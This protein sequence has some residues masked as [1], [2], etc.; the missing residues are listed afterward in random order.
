MAIKKRKTK[1]RVNEAGNYTKPTLRKRIFAR[2]KAGVAKA[3]SPDNGQQEK[4]HPDVGKSIQKAKGGG[5][6]ADGKR[7][8]TFFQRRKGTWV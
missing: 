2:I 1:S 6:K 8:S 7:S 3:A 5:Y 4:P